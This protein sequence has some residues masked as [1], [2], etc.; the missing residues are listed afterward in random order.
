MST[1]PWYRTWKARIGLRL[2]GLTLLLATAADGRLLH[3]LVSLNA[4]SGITPLELLL[5]ALAFLSASAGM[6]MLLMGGR[7]WQPVPLSNRWTTYGV[8]CPVVSHVEARGR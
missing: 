5:A 1:K 6:A 7:L 3:H 4:T 8:P 2:A